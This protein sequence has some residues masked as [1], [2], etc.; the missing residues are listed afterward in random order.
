MALGR[1][2]Y[3]QA[4]LAL[5]ANSTALEVMQ[6][7]LFMRVMLLLGVKTGTNGTNGAP[8]AGSL[9]T[10]VSSS[11]GSTFSSVT[12]LW[13]T[14]FDA[15]KIIRGAFGA[16]PKSHFTLK[17][18]ANVDG[19]GLGHFWWLTVGFEGAGN[20]RYTLRLHKTAPTG[21]TV[22][23]LPST[24]SDIVL[25]PTLQDVATVVHRAFFVVDANGA[26]Y[27]HL[28]HSGAG[29]AHKVTG[30]LPFE[31]PDSTDQNPIMLIDTGIASGRGA[32]GNTDSTSFGGSSGYNG[33]DG[34]NCL[35]PLGDYF[36][37]ANQGGN[38]PLFPGGGWMALDKNNQGSSRADTLSVP[39]GYLNSNPASPAINATRGLIP[40]WLVG[41]VAK[42]VGLVD[43]D[44]GTSERM[45]I[46]NT[47]VPNGGVTPTL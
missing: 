17:S 18:P 31:G 37:G 1:L 24:A 3:A 21:G 9:W 35:S 33:T 23:V 45:L 27:M 10:F 44:T 26:H 47:W 19:M 29:I 40:D 11:D 42:N 46:G 6:A 2:W 28:A 30:V 4:N 5:D 12:N 13:G 7:W 43:P 34:F 15:S 14:S 41:N 38:G 36:S 25:L 32:L 8:P 20:T 16:N 39:F 22:N